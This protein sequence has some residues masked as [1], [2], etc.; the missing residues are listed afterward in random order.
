MG[1]VD[2]VCLWSSLYAYGLHYYKRQM[3]KVLGCLTFMKFDEFYGEEVEHEEVL[4]YLVAVLIIL[5]FI[6]A[7]VAWVW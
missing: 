6:A 7:L 4:L 2:I 5:S 3:L 1:I